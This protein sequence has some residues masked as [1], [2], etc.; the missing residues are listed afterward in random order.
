M[1][2]K[3]DFSANQH[4]PNREHLLKFAATFVR[5]EF[6]SRWVHI[7][8]ERPENALVELHKFERHFDSRACS[9]LDPKVDRDSTLLDEFGDV[10]GVYFD[11]KSGAASLR[12]SE[13]LD[14]MR[15]YQDDALLSLDPGKLGIFFHH[16]R[17]VWV[18][19]G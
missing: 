9:L 2:N 8:C 3:V 17:M 10:T 1:K 12:L 13:A 16:D 7:L 11:G 15:P 18:C 6:R 5:P 19:R 14:R 4:E